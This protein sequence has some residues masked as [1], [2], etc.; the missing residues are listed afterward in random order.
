MDNK[1]VITVKD[2]NID[3]NAGDYDKG[4]LLDLLLISTIKIASTELTMEQILK[5]VAYKYEVY[6]DLPV[7]NSEGE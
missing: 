2:R 1:V 7:E 4:E 6:G 5:L 3:V